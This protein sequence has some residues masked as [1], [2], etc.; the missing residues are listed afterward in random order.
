MIEDEYDGYV[1]ALYQ[2]GKTVNDE[3]KIVTAFRQHLNQDLTQFVMVKNTGR[4]Y[5]ADENATQLSV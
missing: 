5:L 2:D 3:A 1:Q 4:A